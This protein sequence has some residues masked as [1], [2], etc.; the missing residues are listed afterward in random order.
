[1]GTFAD[2]LRRKTGGEIGALIAIILRSIATRL[3]VETEVDA[4]C[5]LELNG[6]VRYILQTKYPRALRVLYA[7]NAAPVLDFYHSTA[8]KINQLHMSL[9]LPLQTTVSP[10]H[11]GATHEFLHPQSQPPAT[12]R[13]GA[14][15]ARVACGD[16]EHVDDFFCGG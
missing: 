8:K 1:M 3:R 4:A 6:Q 10:P 15:G 2:Q 16:K 11:A 12:A 14:R 7:S 13:E 5:Q 9:N